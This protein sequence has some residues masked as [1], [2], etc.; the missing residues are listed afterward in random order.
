MMLSSWFLRRFGVG[1]QQKDM[2][3]NMA[4]LGF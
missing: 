1:D 3:F 2:A 4:V